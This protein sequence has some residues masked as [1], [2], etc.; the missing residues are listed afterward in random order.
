LRHTNTQQSWNT[1]S[2]EVEVVEMKTQ[3]L[4]VGVLCAMVKAQNY[5]Y[6]GQ[7]GHVPIIKNG[8]PIDTPEV[9]AARAAHFEAYEKAKALAARKP[10]TGRYQEFQQRE[11]QQQYQPQQYQSQQYQPQ[12]Y[13]QQHYQP[14]Q[15][16]QQHYQPPQYQTNVIYGQPA[17]Q[18]YAIGAYSSGKHH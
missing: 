8:V 13:Q 1:I 4:L 16:T 9:Q 14:Q 7:S 3:F 2:E 18:H 6:Q 10:S 5:A 15:Y 17:Q 11:Y 12:R